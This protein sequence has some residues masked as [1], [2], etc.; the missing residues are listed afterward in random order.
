MCVNQKEI[1]N[2]YSDQYLLVKCGHCKSDLQERARLRKFKVE[3]EICDLSNSE[4]HFCTLSY[5]NDFI[6]YFDI[7]DY[8]LWIRQ[9]IPWFPVYRNDE[10]YSKHM[11]SKYGKKVDILKHRGFHIIQNIDYSFMSTSEH[12]VDM[13]DFPSPD[14]YRFHDDF[15]RL[16]RIVDGHDEFD[17]YKVGVLWTP[18]IQKFFKRL[19]NRIDVPFSYYYIGEYGGTYGRPHYHILFRTPVLSEQ[20]TFTF[21]NAIVESWPFCNWNT[22]RS[23]AFPKSVKPAS[24]LSSYTNRYSDIPVLFQK[25][26]EMRP[27]ANHS[28][29]FGLQNSAF[30]REALLQKIDSRDV[31][32]I[33]KINIEG[34]PT[35][36]VFPVPAYVINRFF[37]R[38]KRYSS[39][40]VDEVHQ[41]LQLAANEPRIFEV[42]ACIE[43][44]GYRIVYNKFHIHAYQ[45]Y[46][47]LFRQFMYILDVDEIHLHRILVRLL[48]CYNRVFSDQ[49]ERSFL[50]YAIL[51]HRVW[52]LYH[53]LINNR[54]YEEIK[55]FPILV[56][57]QYYYNLFRFLLYRDSLF[58]HVQFNPDVFCFF[59]HYIRWP[60]WIFNPNKFPLTIFKT[61]RNEEWYETYRK[62]RQVKSF[63]LDRYAA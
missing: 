25:C 9:E 30:S 17:L 41:L 15:S 3:D 48:N 32:F 6:P 53:T 4:I 20:E 24:Y 51:W 63:N 28:K 11:V 60:T 19:K 38:F 59:N 50:E 52:Y 12:Q 26:K 43:V 44:A 7:R 8:A 58:H 10:I 5:S 49:S 40:S 13:Y 22:Q 61:K 27:C 18:D 37:P 45:P 2:K 29:G 39:L 36:S 62:D 21:E 34:V 42:D 14:W 57:A 54:H 23:Q 35:D 55:D 47:S 46:E 1:Y 31:S 16:H 56:Q 33:R